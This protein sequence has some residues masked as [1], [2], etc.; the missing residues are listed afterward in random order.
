MKLIRIIVIELL[1]KK[2]SRKKYLKKKK[3]KIYEKILILSF[4]NKIIFR[5]NL[6]KTIKKKYKLKLIMNLKMGN[7]K[8]YFFKSGKKK[9]KIFF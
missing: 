1:K 7:K 5:R 9:E 2:I 3:N 8:K 4:K 6:Y